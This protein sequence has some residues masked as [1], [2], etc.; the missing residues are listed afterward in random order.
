MST[1]SLPSLRWALTERSSWL[2]KKLGDFCSS[3]VQLP[4][5]TWSIGTSGYDDAWSL[6]N[7][8]HVPDPYAASMHRRSVLKCSR[9]GAV[10]PSSPERCE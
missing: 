7:A 3:P 10:V 8:G 9:A 6:S 4:V 2:V 5:H 1:K